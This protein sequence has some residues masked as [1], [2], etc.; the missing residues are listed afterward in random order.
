M[1]GR[2]NRT[3][4]SDRRRRTEEDSLKEEDTGES[5]AADAAPQPPTKGKPAK[6]S[7]ATPCPETLPLEE[8]HYSYTDGL[9]LDRNRTRAETDKFL[10]HHRFKGTR[11]VDWYAGW[12]NWMR[13][14]VQYDGAPKPSANG[15]VPSDEPRPKW[16][17]RTY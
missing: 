16:N 9:G 11:G 10:A 13:R 1:D 15:A 3:P 6:S 2:F 17:V 8:K 12:Q 5:V 14:A 7:R 4:V